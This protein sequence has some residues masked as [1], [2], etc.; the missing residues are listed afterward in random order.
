MINHFIR[1]IDRHRRL[2]SAIGA[3][4][5]AVGCA[6]YAKFLTL[7]AFLYLTDDVL[8]YSGAVYNA[9]WWGFVR[10]AIERYEKTLMTKR[11]N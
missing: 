2:L 6:V 1:F 3:I 11:S 8:L 10:P 4:W 7:P 9:A 5:F